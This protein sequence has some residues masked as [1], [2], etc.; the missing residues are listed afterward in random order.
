MGL[1][2]SPLFCS[3]NSS[4]ELLVFMMMDGDPIKNKL[5]SILISYLFPNQGK[6][7][8]SSLFLCFFV[9]QIFKIQRC[10]FIDIHAGETYHCFS[11]SIS[12]SL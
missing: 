8:F 10:V 1:L 4:Q 6:I 5:F 7:L 11:C 9:F 2:L 3:T 12:D